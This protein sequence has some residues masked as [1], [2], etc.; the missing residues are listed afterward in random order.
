MADLLECLLQIKG[1]RETADRIATLV[2]DAGAAMTL[3]QERASRAQELLA[4]LV[5]AEVRHA[6]WLRAML[7]TDCPALVQIGSAAIEPPGAR[8]AHQLDRFLRER[9]G[10][11]QILDRCSA[12]DLS[13]TG[14][15]PDGS[16]VAVAD[17]VAWMLAT[18]VEVVGDLRRAL[19]ML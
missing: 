18:D 5:D 1:L 8:P 13:R 3:D 17:L 4:R 19:L 15:R 6:G 7:E 11:L 9:A 10:N 16:R 12:Q 14:R 2:R